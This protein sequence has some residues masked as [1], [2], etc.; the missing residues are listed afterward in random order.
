MKKYLTEYRVLWA[1]IYGLG[2]YI[3]YLILTTF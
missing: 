2:A 1:G 3:V